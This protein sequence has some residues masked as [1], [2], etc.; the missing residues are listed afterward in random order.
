MLFDRPA[1]FPYII[2][3][4]A[5]LCLPKLSR[6]CSLCNRKSREITQRC[7]NPL[8][9][10]LRASYYRGMIGYAINLVLL[11][12]KHHPRIPVRGAWSL[13][14]QTLIHLPPNTLFCMC[15]IYEGPSLRLE[16]SISM[17]ASRGCYDCEG[18]WSTAVWILFCRRAPD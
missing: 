18:H 11:D 1:C 3:V 9:H 6:R 5:V 8:E 14:W 12:L 4:Y 2:G 7:G 17:H 13:V 15:Q 16:L 10:G